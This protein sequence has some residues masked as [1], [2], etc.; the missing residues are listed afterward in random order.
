LTSHPFK[1][2][3]FIWCAFPLT[4]NPDPPGPEHIVYT[5]A[6]SGVPGDYSAL[7]AYTTSRVR[8]SP[9]PVGVRRFDMPEAGRMGHQRPFLL[10]LSRLGHLPA[11][12]A[13]FPRLDLPDRGVI[14]SAPKPLQAVLEQAVIDLYRQRPDAIEHLG[15]N[16]PG[17]RSR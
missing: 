9:L 3:D 5:L 8:P 4:E 2:G 12:S 15:P 10:N 6:A 7:V 13:Y 16:R 14:G 11:T 1:Q 17:K